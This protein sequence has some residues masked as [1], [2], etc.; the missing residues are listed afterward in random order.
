MKLEC[1][2]D[3]DLIRRIFEISLHH[4]QFIEIC[5]QCKICCSHR[6]CPFHS[7]GTSASIKCLYTIVYTLSNKSTVLFIS[8]TAILRTAAGELIQ[9]RFFL[10]PAAFPGASREGLPDCLRRT[11]FTGLPPFRSLR[12]SFFF[13]SGTGFF[14]G[15]GRF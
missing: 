3:D 15:A 14:H 7:A 9:E 5:K 10:R 8:H 13:F 12:G 1:V 4:C 2:E 6:I 11:V